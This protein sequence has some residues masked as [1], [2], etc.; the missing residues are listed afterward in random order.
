M[1]ITNARIFNGKEFIKE[2][3]IEVKNGRICRVFHNKNKRLKNCEDIKGDIL[4]PGLI[5]IHTHGAGGIN[6]LEIKNKKDIKIIKES[7]AKNGTTSVVLTTVYSYFK[8]EHLRLIN[9]YKNI[10]SGAR[11]LGIYLESP[12]VNLNKK[13][14]I[15][16]EFVMKEVDD[17][18]FLI[19]DVAICC[20]HSLKIITIA[21]EVKEA[22]KVINYFRKQGVII[23]FGH[24]AA[25]Y[26]K[27]K[28][29]IKS[30][31]KLS[32]HFFNAMN[33]LHH[34][35]PGPAVA[36]LENE[37]IFLEIIADGNHIHPAVIKL[38]YNI[39]GKDR[40][41]LITDATGDKILKDGTYKNK[42]YGEI[43]VKNN[44]VYSTDGILIGTNLTLLQMCKNIKK[45]LSLKNED[46]LQMVTYNPARLLNEK[47]GVI[48]RGFLADFV[49]LDKKLNL[50]KVFVNNKWVK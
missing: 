14:M 5:D 7:Y 48:K 39:A 9:K 10:K 34:R 21:P 29:A 31:V 42:R 28:E 37:N 16:D 4:S 32:T 2:N 15:K 43:V 17:S 8:K 38:I 22:K 40:I 33:P 11:I 35:N 27:T 50:K 20:G 25:D 46:V 30:G 24:S 41:I 44:G 36:L 6:S 45:W 1:I 12:F 49:I 19:K 3:S 23:A 13:G 26:Q 47:V 18:E